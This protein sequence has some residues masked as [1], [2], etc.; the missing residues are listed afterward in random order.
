[1][2]K[3]S[4]IKIFTIPNEI[5]LYKGIEEKIEKLFNLKAKIL[6]ISEA[7]KTGKSTKA[8]PGKPGLFLE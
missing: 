5:E 7:S 3:K 4:S 2:R 1:M 8:K 6:S